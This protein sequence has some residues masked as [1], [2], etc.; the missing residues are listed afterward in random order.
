MQL[1]VVT[2]SDSALAI[3]PEELRRQPGWL[4]STARTYRE[5][6]AA[7]GN[8]H[9]DAVLAAAPA[10]V[11]ENSDDFHDFNAFLRAMDAQRIA[12]IV[13]SRDGR[14]DPPRDASLIETVNR[15]ISVDELR[16]RL[17]IIERYHGL[18]RR[19]ERELL[20]MQRL[21]MRL[22]QHFV[23]I[24]QELRLAGRLQRDFLPDLTEPIGGLSFVSL[25]KPA[26]WVSGDMFDV[27]RVDD[28]RTG[29]Y[30]AD[31]VGHG[32]A[33]GLLTMFIYRTIVPK[34]APGEGHRIV[35]PS[36]ALR[37]LND[38]IAHQSLPHCQFV[39]AC[40]GLF[41]QR[42]NRLTLARG[43]HPYPLLI[44]REGAISE[45]KA[46]GGLV[47]VLEGEEFPCIDVILR[48]GDRVLLYTDGVE[49]LV[50][51]GSEPHA[52]EVPLRPIL[53]CLIDQPMR[54][55]M[56]EF[57]RVVDR[58]TGCADPKD[59]VTFLGLERLP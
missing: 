57:E 53:K 19:L 23:E 25:Y 41:D 50:T 27:F 58:R 12:G 59:D 6:L 20:T 52:D 10:N 28:H 30:I 34:Q 40:Y 11:A 47:G 54:F 24:D 5:A 33:A 13:V 15:P 32:M 38:A 46:P 14:S 37:T 22:N 42:D 49:H 45:I 16:G 56:S 18:V 7:T 35:G 39:T 31:A 29:F 9:V 44:T 3:D 26:S 2:P 8:G 55:W 48:P 36:E 17:A 21:G 43:G 1:L 4:V 51:P